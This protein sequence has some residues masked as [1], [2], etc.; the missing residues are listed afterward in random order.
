V[1]LQL[2]FCRRSN[3]RF[4][5]FTTGFLSQ[6]K[7]AMRC[8]YNWVPVAVQPGD[9]VP[10]KLGSV[11]IETGGSVLLKLGFC[12]SR[13]RQFGAFTTVFMSQYKPAVWC[14]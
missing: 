9:S 4:G 10:L 11:A 8:L 7:P 5:A 6:Y 12:R 13:N 14:L 1:P 3:R 2:G